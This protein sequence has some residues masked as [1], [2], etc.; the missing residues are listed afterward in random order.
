M[1]DLVI[2]GDIFRRICPLYSREVN[3]LNLRNEADDMKRLQW[4]KR[5]AILSDV[6]MMYLLTKG[7]AY[8][9]IWFLLE[10]LA[11]SI[12]DDG[13]IYVSPSQ[14]MTVDFLAKTIRRSKKQVEKALDVYEEIDLL[15][16]DEKGGLQLLTWNKIQDYARLEKQREKK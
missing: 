12:N 14:P 7:D 6:Q 10:D 11:A 9:V 4:V 8:V 13:K 2:F 1:N 5:Q 15:A 3:F 16:R